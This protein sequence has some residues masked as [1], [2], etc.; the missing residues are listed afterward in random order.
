MSHVEEAKQERRAERAKT[1]MS[2]AAALIAVVVFGII[3]VG[4]GL[5]LGL[6]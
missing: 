2:A 3:A 1:R 5:Y 6:R 4:I